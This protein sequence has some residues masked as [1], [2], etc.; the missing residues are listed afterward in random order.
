MFVQTFVEIC[1][2]RQ[3]Y[4]LLFPLQGYCQRLLDAGGVAK[5]KAKSL[6]REIRALQSNA[7]QARGHAAVRG[8]YFFPYFLCP[9]D[10]SIIPTDSIFHKRSL[11]FKC[12]LEIDVH[13][14]APNCMKYQ[15][16]HLFHHF[17]QNLIT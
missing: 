2:I 16:G 9:Y 11:G 13:S 6:L 3:L 10:F 7:V 12:M 8:E 15:N 14:L 4:Y 5:E 1:Q 17:F